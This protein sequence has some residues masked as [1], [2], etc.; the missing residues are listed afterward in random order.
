MASASRSRTKIRLA[1]VTTDRSTI[2]QLANSGRWFKAS[3]Q[4]EETRN[5]IEDINK[6]GDDVYV[7][8]GY[9]TMI[10][11]KALGND[12]ESLSLKTW[13]RLPVVEA[14]AVLGVV[15]TLSGIGDPGIEISR[16]T[17]LNY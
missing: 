15:T 17:D 14:V 7:V 1:A 13:L 9:Q 4:N 2:I 5:W 8:V 6:T 10:D 12:I 3:L 11:A 16:R